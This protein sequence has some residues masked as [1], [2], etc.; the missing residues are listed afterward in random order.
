MVKVAFEK[1]FIRKRVERK[2]SSPFS[3]FFLYCLTFVFYLAFKFSTGDPMKV[4]D[5][6][7]NSARCLQ[8][9]LG[10][11]RKVT[12]KSGRLLNFKFLSAYMSLQYLF[13]KSINGKKR[14]SRVKQKEKNLPSTAPTRVNIV[15]RLFIPS[16]YPLFLLWLL[17]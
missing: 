10:E 3:A 1:Q 12:T 11:K 8:S 13:V 5:M 17:L 9:T 7:L 15:N 2:P 6:S 14:N 16:F 4:P